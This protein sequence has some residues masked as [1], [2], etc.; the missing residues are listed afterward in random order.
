MYG[1]SD[2]QEQT[3]CEL[4]RYREPNASWGTNWR[5]CVRNSPAAECPSG[6][7]Q[8]GTLSHNN[9][10]NGF[11]LGQYT[12]ATIDDCRH[13]CDNT[14]NCVAFMYGGA[15]LS[16]GD[17]CELSNNKVPDATWGTNWRF[18]AMNEARRRLIELEN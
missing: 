16:E 10:K 9:D 15:D 11:G 3:T 6:Y 8:V 12:K 7:D 1:G 18:C 17:K 5:F 2:L 14:S 13:L 4:G